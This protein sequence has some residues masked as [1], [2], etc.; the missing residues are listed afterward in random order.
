MVYYRDAL[1][2]S[3]GYTPTRQP[4]NLIAGFRV[5]RLQETPTLYQAS[6]Q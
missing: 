6:L 4:V 3:I 5:I 2:H 1:M